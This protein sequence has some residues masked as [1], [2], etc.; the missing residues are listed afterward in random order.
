MTTRT[1]KKLVQLSLTNGVLDKSKVLSFTSSLKRKE[2][3]Q[4]IKALKTFEKEQSI[5]VRAAFAP[6]DFDKKMFTSLFLNKHI[7]FETSP[8]LLLGIK[9]I[10]NDMEYELNLK[11]KLESMLS[12]LS[13]RND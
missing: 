12:Y 6:S 10:D 11:N 9:I 8:S 1:L 5:I 4:Y 3:K 7:V 2:L 13:K